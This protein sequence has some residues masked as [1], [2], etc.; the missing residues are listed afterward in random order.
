[1]VFSEQQ[2]R[3]DLFEWSFHME[4]FDVCFFRLMPRT[5]YIYIYIYKKQRTFFYVNPLENNTEIVFCFHFK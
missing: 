5:M 4:G 1:M 3:D 2:L